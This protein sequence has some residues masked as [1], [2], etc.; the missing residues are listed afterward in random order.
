MEALVLQLDLPGAKPRVLEPGQSMLLGRTPGNDLMVASVRVSSHHAA[1][2]LLG[3][4]WVIRDLGSRNGTFVNG[5]RSN[6]TVIRDGDVLHLA[7]VRVF[8]SSRALPRPVDFEA[9]VVDE[10]IGSR[11]KGCIERSSVSGFQPVERV[12]DTEQLRRDYEKLRLAQR[13]AL[14]LGAEW[15]I[16]RLLARLLAFCLQVLP[17]ENGV[18]MLREPGGHQMVPRM[19]RH[20]AA[21]AAPVLVSRSVVDRVVRSG[22]ALLIEDAGVHEALRSAKS[23]VSGN[24]RSL[25]AV[26]LLIRDEVRGVLCLDSRSD[27]ALFDERD[28]YLLTGIAAQASVALD[29]RDQVEARDREEEKRRFLSRFLSPA[30][31]AD[32][33]RGRLAIDRE[34]RRQAVVVLFADMRD[35]VGFAERSGPEGTAAVLNE[36]YRCIEEEVFDNGGVLDKFVG[37]AVMAL[38]GYPEARP[39]DAGRA[40][41]CAQAIQHRIRSMNLHRTQHGVEPVAA[42][43]AI[44]RG[45]AV[46]AC[47]GSQRRMDFTAVGAT[48]NLAARLSGHAGQG[49]ILISTAMAERLMGTYDLFELPELEV[50]G[51]SEPVRAFRV[52]W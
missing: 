46:V 38:W 40:V 27:S 21:H 44:H 49:E 9:S 15:D 39:D 50:R 8:V 7:D 31:V 23:I 12:R 6:R 22:E 20:R 36:L 4:G 26:P 43:I 47:L 14:R 11:V 2:E 17:A 33:Q 41:A 24:I 19:V 51:K 32:V 37:D 34:P 45:E 25:L 10:I 1:I 5:V 18:V 52:G 42:G 48:V 35:L 13:L 29:Y 3:E 16:E 28:L 30:L